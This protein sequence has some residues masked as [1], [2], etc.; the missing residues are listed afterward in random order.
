LR[1]GLRA[2]VGVAAGFVAAQASVTCSPYFLSA[3]IGDWGYSAAG[4]GALYAVEMGAF[5]LAMLVAAPRVDRLSLRGLALT[6]MLLIALG[7]FGSAVARPLDLMVA[8]RLSAGFGAGWVS[9]AATAAAARSAAPARVYAAATA[10]M[11]V[12]FAVMYPAIAAAGHFR[13]PVGMFLLLGA[14]TV[15]LI[16]AVRALAHGARPA[17][18]QAPPAGASSTTARHVGRAYLPGLAALAAMLAFNYG[19]LA[20]WPFTERIGENLGLTMDRISLLTAV[21][22]ALAAFGGVVAN[23]LGTRFGFSR[24]L[25]AGLLLQAAGCVAVCHAASEWQFLLTY[26]WYLGVWYYCYAYILAVAAAADPVGKLAVLTGMGY[27]VSS[28]LGGLS[29]GF[30]VESYSLKS[31]GWLAVAGCGLALM[32][33]VPV[34]RRIDREPMP[35]ATVAT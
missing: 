8:A 6:G 23:W 2:Y 11:T 4:V 3:L 28:A 14:V 27:P 21:G 12:V 34:C 15:L 9:A 35:Y 30:L 17:S 32:L 25:A 18:M 1:P 16:P 31:I 29:A 13:G 22:S 20:V 26:T 33:L 7:Q 19:A 24:P 10:V 5:A